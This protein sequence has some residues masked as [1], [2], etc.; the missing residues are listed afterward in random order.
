MQVTGIA[1]SDVML[2]PAH[3]TGEEV[4]VQRDIGLCPGRHVAKLPAQV[5]YSH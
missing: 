1:F 3:M 4:K 2:S 5:A